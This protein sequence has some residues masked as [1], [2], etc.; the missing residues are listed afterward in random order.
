MNAGTSKKD[1]KLSDLRK[2][3]LGVIALAAGTP[4]FAQTQ[5]PVYPGASAPIAV[6]VILL[7]ILVS[8][9]V[10]STTAF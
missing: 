7:G 10:R 8:R 4:I 9:E 2:I 5:A 1:G 6:R 3:T